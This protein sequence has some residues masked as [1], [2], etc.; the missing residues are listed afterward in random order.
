MRRIER[1]KE[2]KVKEEEEAVEV[3]EE[4]VKVQEGGEEEDRV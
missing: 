1:V 2:D 4:E 3:Y